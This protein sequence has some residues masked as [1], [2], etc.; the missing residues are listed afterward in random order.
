MTLLSPHYRS[1]FF[2]SVFDLLNPIP[3]GFFFGT[4]I[5][6]VIYARTAEVLWVHAAAWLVSIGLV[7]AI[8]PRLINFG[9]VWLAGTHSVARAERVDFW[10]NLLAVIAAVLNAFVHSRDA[11]AAVPAGVFLSLLTVVLLGAA[12]I[13]LALNKFRTQGGWA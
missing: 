12:Q 13:V 6:D 7:V 10:L 11:Y 2:T 4:L 5:F 3:Y 8:V 1:R 9:H